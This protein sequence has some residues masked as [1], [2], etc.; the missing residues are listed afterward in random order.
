MP[1]AAIPKGRCVHAGL[2][3]LCTHHL[4]TITKHLVCPVT[5]QVLVLVAPSCPTLYNSVDCSLPGSSVRGTSQAR[6]LEQAVG[7]SSSRG[8]S[9]PRDQTRVSCLLQWQADSL[10]QAPPGKPTKVTG[11]PTESAAT[12]RTT[13]S[14]FHR[15][16]ETE[17]GMGLKSPP[18]PDAKSGAGEQS[19]QLTPW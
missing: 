18:Y 19:V 15:W 4:L 3:S 11:F 1:T 14:A 9:Q 16:G 8:F 6:I 5:R 12:F 10:P 17:T 2:V 13:L 7:I